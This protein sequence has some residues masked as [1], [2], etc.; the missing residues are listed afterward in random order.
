MDPLDLQNTA[1]KGWLRHV[2]E[3]LVCEHQSTPG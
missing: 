3:P 2:V 1:E